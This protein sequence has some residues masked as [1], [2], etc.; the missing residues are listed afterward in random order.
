[1]KETGCPNTMMVEALEE[2]LQLFS[3]IARETYDSQMELKSAAWL[4]RHRAFVSL[5]KSEKGCGSAT[6]SKSSRT[7]MVG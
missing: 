5:L 7:G 4:K 1:M 2:A 6:T 3:L